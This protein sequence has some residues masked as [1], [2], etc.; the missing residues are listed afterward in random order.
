MSFSRKAVS[1]GA[2]LVGLTL[3][4]GF[5]KQQKV[6]LAT[7]SSRRIFSGFE[8]LECHIIEIFIIQTA[9]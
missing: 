5:E 8:H 4:S 1:I 6:F 2:R 7:F 3:L 9:R